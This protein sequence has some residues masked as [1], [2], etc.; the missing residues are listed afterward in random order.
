[1]V[2]SIAEGRGKTP[3]LDRARNIACS[4][5]AA[6]V[7]RGLIPCEQ[8]FCIFLFLLKSSISILLLLYLVVTLSIFPALIDMG[9]RHLLKKMQEVRLCGL[10]ITVATAG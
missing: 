9:L 8:F 2:T 3:K 7:T 5:F 1:M 6:R 10:R 4:S